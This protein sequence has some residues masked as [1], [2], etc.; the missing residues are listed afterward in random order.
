MC[1]LVGLVRHGSGLATL[2][3]E[4]G[5][6]LLDPR[7]AAGPRV[8]TRE[9]F[10]ALQAFQA[11]TLEERMHGRG[12]SAAAMRRRI[13]ADS[14]RRGVLRPGELLVDLIATPDTTIALLASRRGLE[15]RLL[16]GTRVLER[17]GADWRA[18]A[19]TGASPAI[20]EAGMRR[21]AAEVL[22]PMAP[23]LRDARRV[24]ITGGGPLA[25][26]PWAALT[27]PGES[28]VLGT[29]REV[30][31]APSATLFAALRARPGAPAPTVLALGRTTDAA[32]RD[33]PGARRE[34]E[35]LGAQYARV[36]VRMNRGDR[37][38][39]A[40]TADLPR[41]NVLHFAAHADARSATPWQSG[42]LLGAGTGDAAYLRASSVARLRLRADLAVLSGCQSAGAT[43]LAGEGAL[44]LA[45][46][47]LCSGSRS[48]VATLWPVEDRVAQRFMSAFYEALAS[49]RSVAGAVR[50][51]QA[52]LRVHRETA[53]VRDW[54]AFVATGEG[55]TQVRISRRGALLSGAR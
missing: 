35:G 3:A 33:L 24:V 50:D 23:A 36:E 34:L 11:R 19:L 22:T 52:A 29:T 1:V 51:G 20:V 37:G 25:L 5:L 32:G 18:V 26:W 39:D 38:L 43:S 42:F 13:T 46:A 47:F 15:A 49:G 14:L 53:E 30:F 16:P 31:H 48:V 54:A 2:F 7:R 45:S 21:M 12:L 55:S 6:A 27:L 4:Y 10:D 8:R 17:L 40:L 41:W 9:A 28:A 44:G